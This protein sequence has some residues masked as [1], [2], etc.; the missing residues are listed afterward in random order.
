V[1]IYS[2]LIKGLTRRDIHPRSSM[3]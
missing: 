1:R 3:G 2:W